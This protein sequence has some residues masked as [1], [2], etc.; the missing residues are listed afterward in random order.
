VNKVRVV[1]SSKF[2]KSFKKISKG[3]TANQSLR[4]AKAIDNLKKILTVFPESF[5][6]IIFDKSCDIPF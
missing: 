1:V 2:K 6:I 3:L 5:P 4:L